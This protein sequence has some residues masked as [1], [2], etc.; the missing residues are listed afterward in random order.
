MI[1]N[2]MSFACKTS[3]YLSGILSVWSTIYTYFTHHL[4]VG[5]SHREN[6][7][8]KKSRG[9]VTACAVSAPQNF[10]SKMGILP[11]SSDEGQP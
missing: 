6:A 4:V 9:A 7:K 1:R 10:C 3:Y 5:Y 8:E 11:N 2:T